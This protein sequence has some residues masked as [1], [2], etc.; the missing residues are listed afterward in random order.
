[1]IIK[2]YIL[3][4]DKCGKVINT[5]YHYKPNMKRIREDD[6]IVRINNGHVWLICKDC[7]N[8]REQQNDYLSKK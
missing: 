4:C 2:K 1:M 7:A 3:T 5:Y 6:G 8:G